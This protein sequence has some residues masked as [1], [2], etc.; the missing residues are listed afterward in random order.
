MS[1]P[2]NSIRKEFKKHFKFP[3]GSPSFEDAEEYLIDW[4]ISKLEEIVERLEKEKRTPTK[5]DTCTMDDN[6][7][8]DHREIAN[9]ED[10]SNGAY[11]FNQALS[12]AQAII[13]EFISKE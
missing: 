7:C 11:S 8:Y 2:I 3:S 10:I 5:H 6:W 1:K 4:F 9:E 13:K 12:S